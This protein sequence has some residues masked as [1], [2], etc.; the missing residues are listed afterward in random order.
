LPDL[1]V[2]IDA[3]HDRKVKRLRAALRLARS[4]V[5]EYAITEQGSADLKTI[6]NAL[7]S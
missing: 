2:K 1:A 3:L 7:G 4:Y 6:D 5:R